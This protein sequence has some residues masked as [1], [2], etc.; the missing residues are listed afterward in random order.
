M[1]PSFILAILASGS[2]FETQSSLESFLPL[3]LRSRRPSFREEVDRYIA[4]LGGKE[5]SR[6]QPPPYLVGPSTQR[7]TRE[8]IRAQV[9][10]LLDRGYSPG[11]LT[12]LS[13]L[14]AVETVKDALRHRLDKRGGTAT[15]HEADIASATFR[16]ARDWVRVDDQHLEQLHHVR[17][18]LSRDRHGLGSNDSM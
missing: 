4:W 16:I 8:Q 10:A 15:L 6:G 7:R 14:V 2:L 18:R 12:S 9:S 1:V 13:D 17:R 3:R 5:T 11:R